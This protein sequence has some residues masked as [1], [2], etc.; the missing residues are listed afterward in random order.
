METYLEP[1]R[2]GVLTTRKDGILPHDPI[3]GILPPLWFRPPKQNHAGSI[4]L[5]SCKPTL[6]SHKSIQKPPFLDHL[7]RQTMESIDWFQ[8]VSGKNL[9]ENPFFHGKI[10]GFRLRFSLS[11]QPIDRGFF[12][13]N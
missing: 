4:G 13:A 5:P 12:C 3:V 7:P 6:V 11:R 1:F 9:Q 2:M 8:D 10:D